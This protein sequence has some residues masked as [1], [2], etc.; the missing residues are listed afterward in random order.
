MIAARWR[1]IAGACVALALSVGAVAAQDAFPT[2]PIKRIVPLAVGGGIDFT[3]RATAQKLSDVIGQQV[4][5]ENQGGA[6]GTL[7]INAVV[8]A[9]PDGYTLLYHSVSGVVSSVV[10]KDLPYDW[11]RDLAPVSLVTRFAPVLIINPALPA[12]DLKEFI[13]LAKASPGKF[14]YGSSGPGTGI[15]LAS[16]LFKVAAGVDILHVPYRGNA[17]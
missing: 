16:E 10:G 5:V 12:R 1:V 7:G 13:A 11:L 3:A 8:R 2:K 4:V 14:S 15:H 6:G 17:A 9:A